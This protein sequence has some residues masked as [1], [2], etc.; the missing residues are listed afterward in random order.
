MPL[1]E[2]ERTETLESIEARVHHEAIEMERE[3]GSTAS[4]YPGDARLVL[5]QVKPQQK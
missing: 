3:M 5:L 4:A 2:L 1:Q